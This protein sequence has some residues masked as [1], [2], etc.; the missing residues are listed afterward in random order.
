MDVS[1]LTVTWNSADFV[2]R[3]FE[4]VKK[5]SDGLSYE[6][7]VADN[8]SVDGTVTEIRK[9]FPD[10]ALTV[11]SK[12]L[13][14][15]A[16][17]N[18]LVKKSSGKYFLLLNPDMEVGEGSLKKLIEFAKQHPKAGI[19]GGVLYNEA[20]VIKNNALPRRFPKFF[21]QL[22]ILL[23]I[24]HIFPKLLNE[25]LQTGFD[26]SKAQ[27]VDSVQGSFMLVS[28]E[29]YSKLGKL[30]DERFFI[31]FE[32]VDLCQ[33]A[34]KLGYEVWFTPDAKAIDFG[35][36]SFAKQKLFWKQYQF[37]KSL[38]N[39]FFKWESF[40]AGICLAIIAAFVLAVTW[41]IDL[42]HDNNSDIN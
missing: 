29:V 3:Q 16:A 2:L 6:Q 31:W 23:K 20:G 14:F 41:V 9:K 8:N 7:L 26:F 12:N 21:D 11:F 5:G 37:A 34:K 1:I 39:Y 36:R 38:I 15:A 30:F 18:E 32:D 33:E 25:Y 13:G 19:V 28:R 22:V 35:G 27:A 42:V 40:L 24:H 4:S 10:L 17:N